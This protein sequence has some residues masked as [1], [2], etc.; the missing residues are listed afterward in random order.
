LAAAHALLAEN[1]DSEVAP[2]L[3]QAITMEPKNAAAYELLGHVL[4]NEGAFDAARENFERAIFHG[5]L[6]AGCYYDL[7]RCRRLTEADTDLL[8]RMQTALDQPKLEA[9][10]RLKLHLALGKAYDDFGQFEKAMQHFDAADHFRTPLARFDLPAF[11]AE[12]DQLIAL[13]TPDA[14]SRLASYGSADTTPLM[15]L[16]MPRSGTTLVEQMLSR[17]K[18]IAAGGE[19]HFWGRRGALI[20]QTGL[21]ALDAESMTGLAADYLKTLRAIA[22]GADRVTDKMPYNFLWAGLVHVVFPRATILHCRRSPIDTALSIHQTHFAP[23]LRFPTGGSALVGYYRAYERLM[24]HWRR[25]LPAERFIEVDYEALAAHPEPAA[26]RMIASTGLAWDAACLQPEHNP[27]IVK[28]ASKWQARQPVYQTAVGRWRRYEPH[29]G[30]L[31][32]LA[33]GDQADRV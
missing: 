4:A 22:P 11:N 27:R 18:Q 28:T 19:L 23:K 15:I 14:V 32:P 17:H 16:G 20:R 6:L 21:P 33:A 8:A 24:V 5:K 9:G 30:P 29:L 31:A 25:V 10:Q 13:F 1:R 3:R 12:V 7:V 2:I 26:Q